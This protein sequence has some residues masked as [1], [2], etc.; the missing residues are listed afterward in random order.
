MP[1]PAA[2]AVTISAHFCSIISPPEVVSCQVGVSNS[3]NAASAGSLK[4]GFF[5]EDSQP[6]SMTTGVA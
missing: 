3:I 6:H 2:A 1:H 4:W 5:K